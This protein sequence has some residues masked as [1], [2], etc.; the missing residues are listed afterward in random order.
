MLMVIVLPEGMLVLQSTNLD[1][2]GSVLKA[3]ISYVTGDITLAV[4]VTSGE[5]K[6]SNFG[7]NYNC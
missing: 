5:G 2:E 6:D 3:G 4:G 7:D 1:V